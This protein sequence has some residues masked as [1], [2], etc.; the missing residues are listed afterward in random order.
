MISGDTSRE[1]RRTL[2]VALVAGLTYAN[3][4]ANQFALDDQWIVLENPLVHSLSG[5]WRAFGAPYW[6]NG[7]VGQYRPLVIASFALD[8]AIG[9]G[10]GWM[11]HLVNV[12]WHVAA[13]LLVLR[14]ARHVL[15][16][17]GAV[18]AAMLFA[19]HP[20]HVEAVSGVVG[21]SELMATVFV[22][23]A[24]L[25]HRAGQRRAIGW[26]AL[27]LLSKES[28][29]VLMGLAVVHDLLL[30]E[31][32]PGSLAQGWAKLRARRTLYAGYAAVIV[33]YACLLAWVFRGGKNVEVPSVVWIG[34]TPVDRW[35]TM[36]RVV[37]DYVRLMVW[38]WHLAID[39]TPQ[40]LVL[41]TTVTPMV[42]LGTALLLAT[43]GVIAYT[44]RRAPVVAAGL[45]WFAV[46][47]SP[48]SNVFFAAGIVLAERTFYLPSV[49][50]VLVMGWA[51]AVL[52][53]RAW[54]HEA[55]RAAL[56]GALTGVVL[57]FGLRSWV[58][59][60]VWHDNKSLALAWVSTQ[61]ESYRS[62]DYAA[63]VLSRIND[64]PGSAREAARSRALFQADAGPYML[65]S[66]AA[67]A[68]HDSATAVRLLDSA[69]LVAPT[70]GAPLVRRARVDAILQRWPQAMVDARRAYAVDSRMAGA[71]ALEVAAAQH[72]GDVADAR[73]A[74]QRGLAD[75]PR[76]RNLHLGYASMLRAIGDTASARREEQV[77]ATL[78]K[79][80]LDFDAIDVIDQR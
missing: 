51:V 30:T 11:F 2:A 66:E 39:Y 7:L 55:P 42:L 61:P 17:I 54:G 37:P 63:I 24:L 15:P 74:F 22:L 9:H 40:T 21:R 64:W 32:V 27:A 31:D 41:V 34:A 19:V 59:T 36:L 4:L 44:W 52:A 58:R 14:L 10:A 67:L 20:V 78:P 68:M 71:I 28:G 56:V 25:A 73:T 33:A 43:A 48:V 12:A 77:A 5:L 72:L 62:H 38:P 76:N 47:M 65:G 57:L 1:R 50:G 16:E 49:G 35:L 6:P 45:L 3:A 29:I 8:W 79:I 69:V 75:H 60:P 70:E 46:A 18:A 26:Y 80:T 23:A 13:T 53:R